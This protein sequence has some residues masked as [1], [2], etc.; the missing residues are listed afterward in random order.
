MMPVNEMLLIDLNAMTTNRIKKNALQNE[1]GVYLPALAV[2][3]TSI[4]AVIFLLTFNTLL[5]RRASAHF[6]DVAETICV[7]T[8]TDP[9]SHLAESAAE[10]FTES[11]NAAFA[12]SQ[13]QAFVDINR[14]ELTRARLVLP[15]MNEG[16]DFHYNTSGGTPQFNAAIDLTACTVASECEFQGFAYT[17][18]PRPF[19]AFVMHE[20]ASTGNTYGCEF[21]AKVRVF[22]LF[23]I[24]DGM[25]NTDIDGDEITMRT[26][27]AY[28]KMIN[29]RFPNYN[30]SNITAT[31]APGL[32][33]AISTHLP[34]D[35]VD[36]RYQ[37]TNANLID[38]F[39]P[40]NG[41]NAT[42][43]DFSGLGTNL[44][45]AITEKTFTAGS[46]VGWPG[47]AATTNFAG[48]FDFSE[49][50]EMAVA[51]MNPVVLVRN[52]FL[53]VLLQHASRNGYLRGSTEILH[54]G[55]QHRTFDTS[56]APAWPA[57]VNATPRYLNAPVQLVPFGSDLLRPP[58]G[59]SYQLPYIFY[60]TGGG[61]ANWGNATEVPDAT[62]HPTLP[63]DNLPVDAY[64]ANAGLSGDY[65]QGIHPAVP[66]FGYT[67]FGRI[68]PWA[69]NG[70]ATKS[71]RAAGRSHPEWQS[72]HSILANQLRVCAHFYQNA[73]A[74]SAINVPQ[75]AI[76]NAAFEPE[77][78]N[79]N[80]VTF[81]PVFN[82]NQPD[83]DQR[84]P[85]DSVGSA[86][87][88][89]L[90][91]PSCEPA[92]T[93]EYLPKP[94]TNHSGVDAISLVGMLG[95]TQSCP[96]RS[97]VR[98]GANNQM[99]DSDGDG[100]GDTACVKPA[101][102]LRPDYR[103]L[104]Q[105]L[106]GIS[107]AEAVRSPGIFPITSDA[108]PAVGAPFRPFNFNFYA[109]AAN[110]NT[111]LLLVTHKAPRSS[112]ATALR[113]WFESTT[114]IADMWS[115]RRIIV[116][117]IPYNDDELSRAGDLAS[118]FRATYD[119][120]A[121]AAGTC[122][123]TCAADEDFKNVVIIFDPRD[124]DGEG[125]PDA[126]YCDGTAC[127]AAELQAYWNQFASATMGTQD[128][129]LQDLSVALMAHKV[130][131]ENIIRPAERKY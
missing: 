28:H 49:A 22:N 77:E 89:N 53:S 67:F 43:S 120:Q 103:G 56:A 106:S 61:P 48:T 52:T 15:V 25:A 47:L 65:L 62:N 105:Y 126:D 78:F 119:A 1:D 85:F 129:S 99:L 91:D 32:T 116:V 107:N 84:C 42:P 115:Q 5:L 37:F 58:N 118:A 109:A 41:V 100:V 90:N 94:Y 70:T 98:D 30:P 39:S 45:N 50:Y 93:S 40:V 97:L 6:R 9:Y 113:N 122:S 60:D 44:T 121:E 27:Y 104:M 75:V 102:D 69:S 8:A 33:I 114:A 92:I 130:L 24:F 112:E 57:D 96:I 131:V 19:P 72:F 83:P 81:E 35:P 4:I 59:T 125:N 36:V 86:Q 73:G 2:I 95:S 18:S 127:T 74:A 29:G 63:P 87:L 31:E 54:V 108:I 88:I 71:H 21:E 111:P 124:P 55:T 38:R 68:N 7:N 13:L 117:F 46:L 20:R 80:G 51:C 14:F 64:R 16:V 10:V 11:V 3:S 12:T 76:Y 26:F 101:E 66:E 82:P 23:G 34:T 128:A 110:Q 123:A 17:T 79:D